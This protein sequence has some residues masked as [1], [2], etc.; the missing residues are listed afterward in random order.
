MYLKIANKYFFGA[1]FITAWKVS[2]FGDFLVRIQSECG[3]RQT[4]KAPN[5]NNFYAVYVSWILQNLSYYIILYHCRMLSV[6][7]FFLFVFYIYLLPK[8]KE[9]LEHIIENNYGM[10][11]MIVLVVVS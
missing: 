2:A 9:D 6:D 1:T 10:G 11:S 5:T 4:R 7:P 3:K 8:R